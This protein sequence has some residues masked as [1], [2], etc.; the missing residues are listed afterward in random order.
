MK[1]LASLDTFMMEM[2]THTHREIFLYPIFVRTFIMHYLAPNHPNEPS[3][4]N[5]D[6][7]SSEMDS[8]AS[9]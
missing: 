8:G 9:S 2:R 1:K 7:F 6:G 4:P 5:A 3:D